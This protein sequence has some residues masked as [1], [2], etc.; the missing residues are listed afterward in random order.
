MDYELEKHLQFTEINIELNESYEKRNKN[1]YKKPEQYINEEDIDF[2]QL[3]I[4]CDSY[5]NSPKA[6][7]KERYHEI[8]SRVELVINK[9]GR[10]LIKNLNK[11]EMLSSEN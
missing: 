4:K 11:L 9:M 6:E 5:K 10:K 2:S 7:E 3:K 8:K 1:F